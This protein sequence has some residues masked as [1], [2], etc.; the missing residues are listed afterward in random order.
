M[1]RDR[2]GREDAYGI[3]A[4][5]SIARKASY[6]LATVQRK[7]GFGCWLKDDFCWASWIEFCYSILELTLQESRCFFRFPRNP[8]IYWLQRRTCLQSSQET[9]YLFVPSLPLHHQLP[10]C[11]LNADLNP[12]ILASFIEIHHGIEVRFIST[13]MVNSFVFKALMNTG[14][15]QRKEVRESNLLGNPKRVYFLWTSYCE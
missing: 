13:Y 5:L 3:M 8:P 10:Y 1:Q 7:R 4:H 15:P 6:L 11:L 14:S 2:V 9:C 12:T